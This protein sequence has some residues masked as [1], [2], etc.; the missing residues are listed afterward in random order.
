M[1]QSGK[2]DQAYQHALEILASP[3]KI[4]YA[5]DTKLGPPKKR[6][7]SCGMNSCEDL[8]D[9]EHARLNTV[10]DALGEGSD[11]EII[12]PP[13]LTT[14]L[15]IALVKKQNGDGHGLQVARK[16]F[17]DLRSRIRS[18]MRGSP[19]LALNYEID[20]VSVRGQD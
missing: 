16:I 7:L 8:D 12:H 1:Y 4:I 9:V 5:Y 10:I 13:L 18:Q 6:D 15:V 20:L 11:D 17:R 2:L 14:L 19:L 3:A